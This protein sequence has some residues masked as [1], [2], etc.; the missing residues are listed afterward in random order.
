MRYRDYY[1]DTS[2]DQGIERYNRET[3]GTDICKG[4][5]CVVYAENDDQHANPLDEFCIA[6][7]YEISDTSHEA[8]EDGIRKYVDDHYTVLKEAA[9]EAVT[10]E[11]QND[12]LIQQM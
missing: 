1:I 2:F 5:Y 4:Y 7:E 10:T 3:R 12:I 9:K 8:M 6:E 11:D